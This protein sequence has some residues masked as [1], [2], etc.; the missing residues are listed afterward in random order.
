MKGIDSNP[1]SRAGFT[2]VELLIVIVVIAILAA[3]SIVAYNGIQ[4][5]AGD[6][7][8]AAIARNFENGLQVHKAGD[9]DGRIVVTP[10]HVSSREEYVQ[11]NNI[12]GLGGDLCIR[13]FDDS[14]HACFPVLV[15]GQVPVYDK[16]KIYVQ[17]FWDANGYVSLTY[18]YW[19]H[20]DNGWK[21]KSFTTSSRLDQSRDLYVE[22]CYPFALQDQA[23]YDEDCRFTGHYLS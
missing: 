10:N 21:G 20:R 8:V 4:A 7:R 2:I 12:V 9:A 23:G 22:L 11:S 6:A 16:K 14:D 1:T 5:R 19:S 13:E 3:I 18:R 17:H 15:E